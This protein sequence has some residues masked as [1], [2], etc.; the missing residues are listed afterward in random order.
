MDS[1]CKTSRKDCEEIFVRK[2]SYYKE[3]VG[4]IILI[5]TMMGGVAAWSHTQTTDVATLKNSHESMREEIREM[6]KTYSRMD[7]KLDRILERLH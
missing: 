1:V 4:G 2:S 6:K 3:I 5:I 7:I